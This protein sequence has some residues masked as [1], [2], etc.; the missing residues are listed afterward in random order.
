VLAV[1]LVALVHVRGLGGAFV[2]D[3][4]LLVAWNPD[5][6]DVGSL[7]D[8]VRRPFWSPEMSFWRP[9]TTA[10]LCLGHAVGGG[11]PRVL[12]A[13]SLLA[14]LAA[15][16]AAFLLARRLTGH[17]LVAFAAAVLFGTHPVQVE[18]VAWIAALGDPL[19][20]CAVFVGLN[21]FA[22]WR[23]R[24]SRGIPL[25]ACAC[26]L[27]GLGAKET[28]VTML[29]LV[30]ML[31]LA[32]G[33]G[34]L[35]VAPVRAYGS[36]LGIA[37][38]Y[39]ALRIAVY[40]D[41]GAGFDRAAAIEGLEPLRAVTLPV[42]LL[43]R[44]VWLLSWPATL[45]LVRPVVLSPPLFDGVFSGALAAVTGV[46]VLVAVAVRRRKRILL[47]AVGAVV[48][49]LAP[50]VLCYRN[51]SPFPLADRFAYGAVLGLA[52]ALAW[53]AILS[54]LARR[55]R[56]LGVIAL[57][58]VMLAYAARSV[59]R[60]GA[61]A[62]QGR[63]ATRTARENPEDPVAQYQLAR[64]ILDARG[65]AGDPRGV[66]SARA[67]FG[68]SLELL[69]GPLLSARMPPIEAEIRVGLAW[70]DLLSAKSAADRERARRA[71][72]AVVAEHPDSASAHVGLGVSLAMIGWM[73]RAE[74]AFLRAAEIDPWSGE[75]RHN[76]GRL[77][78]LLRRPEDARRQLEEAL[79]LR[80]E[81]RET[82]ELLTLVR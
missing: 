43:G 11:D 41:A 26:L 34:E 8:L 6:H 28:A 55:H 79:R 52:L 70:C 24:G 25:G 76:L 36:L 74:K 7:W 33:R 17:A 80:P 3:D 37:M 51:V 23:D 59:E 78:L 77:Y 31:D 44:F 75:A 13:I 42:E 9:V 64:W 15:T 2:S 1:G 18:S 35:A 54:P 39:V 62:D 45:T 82:Q 48:I 14:H 57:I 30:L 16:A 19:C 29:G 50:P 10:V 67:A 65:R 68:R 58:A 60:I 66:A 72:D 49:G 27:I 63:L 81:N 69:D 53:G 61:W 73:A 32:R 38:L 5:L 20:W 71:F 40:G 22:T 4:L 46:A 21:T 47:F 12:H 56:R